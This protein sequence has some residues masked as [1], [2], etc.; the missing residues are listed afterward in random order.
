MNFINF[1]YG[2][3]ILMN[4]D[5]FNEFIWDEGNSLPWWLRQ[6]DAKWLGS[7]FYQVSWVSFVKKNSFMPTK[8]T[9]T[10]HFFIIITTDHIDS[11]KSNSDSLLF[12]LPPSPSL[13][14]YSSDPRIGQTPSACFTLLLLSLLPMI[15]L[16]F[17]L[18]T[19]RPSEEF[20][21]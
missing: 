5:N 3:E 10:R 14:P 19:A 21:M 12:T 11:S 8:G 7:E 1:L 2:L 4:Q 13:N 9:T 6:N 20:L 18:M 17:F 16:E 15:H